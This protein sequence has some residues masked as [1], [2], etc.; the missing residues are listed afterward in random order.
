M[1]VL[2]VVVDDGK[3]LATDLK[4]HFEVLGEFESH[5]ADVQ[6]GSLIDERKS[7]TYASAMKICIKSADVSHVARTTMLHLRWTQNVI[8]EFFG[9]VRHALEVAISE[10]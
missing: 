9:Q 10:G 7:R 6:E 4:K 1:G 8:E 3:V 5:L 2:L